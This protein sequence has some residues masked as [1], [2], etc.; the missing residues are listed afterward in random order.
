[1]P[2]SH[3]A[4]AGKKLAGDTGVIDPSAI[5]IHAE[6]SRGTGPLKSHIDAQHSPER[7][8]FKAALTDF[9]SSFGAHDEYGDMPVWAFQKP[10]KDKWDD[11]KMNKLI[12]SAPEGK[13]R[14]FETVQILQKAGVDLNQ[15]HVE[16]GGKAAARKGA[17]PDLHAETAV[18]I[19]K[20]PEHK[21]GFFKNQEKLVNHPA[22]LDRWEALKKKAENKGW[23][24]VKGEMTKLD[25]QG[26]PV[27]AERVAHHPKL[28]RLF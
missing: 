4:V 22:K 7:S 25:R 19:D 10:F 15:V 16:R 6:A 3:R 24:E 12:E 27:G 13:K 21:R 23:K 26:K 2:E 17:H 8:K 20:I 14:F 9:K 11:K 28:R 5:E 18:D 1:M